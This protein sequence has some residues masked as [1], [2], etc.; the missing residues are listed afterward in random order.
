[1]KYSVY[2]RISV[3][4]SLH[5]FFVAETNLANGV[6]FLSGSAGKH[7]KA[8][9]LKTGDRITIC[10]GAGKE[11]NCL[12]KKISNEDAEAKIIGSLN[13][14]TEPSI[15]CTV[16]AGVSKG[17]RSDLTVQKCTEAGACKIVFFPA[18]RS[19]SRISDKNKDA[20]L[21]R[22]RRV[23][24]EAAMQSGRGIIPA[25]FCAVDFAEAVDIAIKS[26]LALFM[27]E[28]GERISIKRAINE[29]GYFSSVAVM[30]GP[31]GGFEKYEADIARSAGLITCSMGPRILR[32]ETAPVI[33][34]AALM[35]HTDNL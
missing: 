19:V 34:L 18:E 3:V 16:L 25:V 7:I 33:A 35:Y 32:C 2:A 4:M 5:R 15:K 11:Y 6:F 20:K 31:E 12:L 24:E 27:Y 28:T 9:R 14:S 29:A 1:M 22:W 13:N 26:D 21:T 23:A 30:T 17:E 8:L 10:D